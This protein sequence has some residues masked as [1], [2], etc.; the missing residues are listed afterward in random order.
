M[1]VDTHRV[2]GHQQQQESLVNDRK[3][4]R[5]SKRSPSSAK[6][7]CYPSCPQLLLNGKGGTKIPWKPKLD[8]TMYSEEPGYTRPFAWKNW[9]QAFLL[10]NQEKQSVWTTSQLKQRSDYFLSICLTTHRPPTIWKKA[11]VTALQKPWKDPLVPKTYIP[12]SLLKPHALRASEY[13]IPEQAGF[14]P[15]KSTT[16]QGLSLMI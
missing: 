11:H 9:K 13:L 6:S 4:P 8:R 15:G 5:K 10:L 7:H 1:V 14:R 12:I 3:A 16:S 2:D